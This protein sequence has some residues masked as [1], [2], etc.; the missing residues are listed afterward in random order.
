MFWNKRIYADAAAATPLSAAARKELL[1]LLDVFGN[2]GALHKEA[3]VAKAELEKARA[4]VAASVSAHADEIF[5]TA[6]GTEGN[7]WAMQG[8]LRP[9][10]HTHKGLHALVLSVE[11]QSALEPLRALEREGLSV[12]EIP[13][14]GDG[15]PDVRALGEMI[16][17]KT[18]FVSVQLVNSEMGAVMPVR[19]IAKEIRKARERRAGERALPLYVHCDASQAALWVDI[20]VERLGVDLLVLDGQKVLGPKG[21]GALYIKRGTP[22]EAILWGGKQEN[23]LRGGTENVPAIGSFARA[24]TD[25]QTGVEARAARVAAVRDYLRADI[26]RKFPGV[27]VHGPL[28]EERVANNINISIPHL[29]GEMAVI[30]MDARGIAISTRSACNTGD[31]SPSH[32]IRALHVPKELA[33]SAIRITLLPD[34]TRAHARRISRT[35]EEV[36]ARYKMR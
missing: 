14:G 26:E 17:D 11:H 34:V 3:V 24:L 31:D 13:V 22:T 4:A 32:V 21:V 8:T 18:V 28:G 25:A 33:K 29:D 19:E 20:N 9:L 2:P 7:N 6:S 10:L 16:T 5:F 15:L 30:A 12:N 23:G 27:V 36:A 1:R 35:L